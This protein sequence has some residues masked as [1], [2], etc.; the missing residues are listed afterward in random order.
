M[1]TAD[2]GI[3]KRVRAATIST[4]YSSSITNTYVISS[5]I[6]KM[7]LDDDSDTFNFFIRP[8]I[9]KDQQAG[10]AYIK[11]PPA[12][13]LRLTPKDPV[14]LDPYEVPELKVR[15]TGKTEHDLTPA[16]G[17]LRKAI[18]AKYGDWEP[19]TLRFLMRSRGL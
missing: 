10:D 7:G 16:L 13:I 15:G 11:N 4:G 1:S 3:D 6:L 19:L 17:D 5:P 8:S 18:L 14:N 9:F 12:V 2:R